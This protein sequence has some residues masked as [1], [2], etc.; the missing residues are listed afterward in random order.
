M[1]KGSEF[2]GNPVAVGGESSFSENFVGVHPP[3]EFVAGQILHASQEGPIPDFPILG[4]APNVADFPLQWKNDIVE[5]GFIRFTEERKADSFD[6]IPQ[7]SI[8][9]L[10]VLLFSTIETAGGDGIT[11]VL[12]S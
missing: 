4:E 11:G 5:R 7:A 3:F 1:G 6:A 12:S 8:S 10:L 2:P 9:E